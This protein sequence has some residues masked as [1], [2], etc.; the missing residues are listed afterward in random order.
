MDDG[1]GAGGLDAYIGFA[2]AGGGAFP[3]RSRTVW[4]PLSRQ[5]T[6]VVSE[7]PPSTAIAFMRTPAPRTLMGVSPGAP[8]IAA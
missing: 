1:L 2:E 4:M 3:R 7:P 5:A 6:M 8:P